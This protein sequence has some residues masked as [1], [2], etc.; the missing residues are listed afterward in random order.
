MYGLLVK[1]YKKFRGVVNN[2]VINQWQQTKVIS[3]DEFSVWKA[4]IPDFEDETIKDFA[5]FYFIIDEILTHKSYNAMLGVAQQVVDLMKKPNDQIKKEVEKIQVM[6]NKA[7]VVTAKQQNIKNIF[8]DIKDIVDDMKNEAENKNNVVPTGYDCIDNQYGGFKKGELTYFCGRKGDGKSVT[9]INI[10]HNAVAQGKNVIYFSL[11]MSTRSCQHRYLSRAMQVPFSD[12]LN[13][14]AD[15]NK[16]K[17]FYINGKEKKQDYWNGINWETKENVG[18][19]VVVSSSFKMTA[20]EMEAVMQQKEEEFGIVFDML[21]SDYAGIM[22][23]STDTTEKRL[24][25]GDIAQEL[26]ELAMKR[27][28]VCLTAAQLNREGSKKKNEG[29]STAHI[30]ES[31]MIAD[32]CDWVIAIFSDDSH[33]SIAHMQ[34]LK[35]RNG[36]MFKVMM[37]KDYAKM[38]LIEEKNLDSWVEQAELELKQKQF[39]ET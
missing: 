10:S 4:C 2:D 8:D 21:V 22:K 35:V 37:R 32:F 26:K 14:R 24:S 7:S 36:S 13:N 12:F 29:L 28:I 18:Q 16:L 17:E 23:P 19:F 3:V 20:A 15:T 6:V 9:L 5:D 30:A 38:T 25:Q 34:A 39:D 31:D 27:D 33:E 1:Y 11:E